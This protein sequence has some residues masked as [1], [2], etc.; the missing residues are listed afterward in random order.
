MYIALFLALIFGLLTLI[1]NP[2]LPIEGV[3]G[4]IILGLFASVKIGELLREN[5]F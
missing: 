3:I 2:L 1:V 4:M 5:R